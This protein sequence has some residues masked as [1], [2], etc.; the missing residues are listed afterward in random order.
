M[1]EVFLSLGSNIGDRA[2]YLAQSVD[3]ISIHIGLII[4]QSAL[5]ETAA[6]GFVSQAFL[7]QVIFV[8][9]SLSPDNLMDNCLEIERKL[10]RQRVSDSGYA[11]RVIDID[12]LFYNNLVYSS[13]S[14]QVPHPLLHER[15]FV[16]VPFCEI[17]PEFIHP[18]LHKSVIELLAECL[19][20]SAVELFSTE[21]QSSENSSEISAE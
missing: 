7:N 16:L 14:I 8:K 3:E 6:W 11:P 15:R 17:A 19:D 13:P 18:V 21:N 1:A 9:T 4:K 12:V 10:G 2:S 5:Y 20:L